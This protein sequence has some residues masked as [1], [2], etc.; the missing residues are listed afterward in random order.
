MRTSIGWDPLRTWASGG[1]SGRHPEVQLPEW[2]GQQV[3]GSYFSPFSNP[4][5]QGEVVRCRCL[6]LVK[7]SKLCRSCIMKDMETIINCIYPRWDLSLVGTLHCV[8]QHCPGCSVDWVSCPS[9]CFIF[10][11]IPEFDNVVPMFFYQKSFYP[12]GS[13]SSLHFRHPSFPQR[14]PSSGGKG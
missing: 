11:I 14:H 10:I 12:Q 9:T 13:E 8:S 6:G 1:D 7:A 3:L 2:S 5:Q 4:C